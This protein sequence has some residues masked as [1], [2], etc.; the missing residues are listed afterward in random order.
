LTNRDRIYIDSVVQIANIQN[1]RQKY[2]ERDLIIAYL[3]G[4]LSKDST[5]TFVYV[6]KHGAHWPYARTYPSSETIF[7][8]SLERNSFIRDRIKSRNSYYNSIRWNVDHFWEVLVDQLKNGDSTFIFYTSDHGQDLDKE[9]IQI[10]HASIYDVSQKEVEVPMWIYT[11]FDKKIIIPDNPIHHHEEIFPILLIEMGYDSSSIKSQFG[12][13]SLSKRHQALYFLT[14][15]VFG[16][17]K[18]HLKPVMSNKN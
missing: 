11:N 2:E 12:N 9:G 10:S 15:D 6:V 4:D 16:R 8:P 3:L 17:S 18:W 7:S 14:G 1:D 13:Y 5:K